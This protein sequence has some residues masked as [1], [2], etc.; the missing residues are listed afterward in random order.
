MS[1]GC[2]DYPM[3]FPGSTMLGWAVLPASLPTP[4][5]EEGLLD[6]TALGGCEE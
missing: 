6:R 5:Y 4:L 1:C 2:W 3:N